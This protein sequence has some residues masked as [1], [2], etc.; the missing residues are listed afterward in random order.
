MQHF[1]GTEE[2]W[3]NKILGNREHSCEQDLFWWGYGAEEKANLFQGETSDLVP[4]QGGPLE[5]YRKNIQEY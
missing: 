1:E 2:H 5:K 3:E 4:S